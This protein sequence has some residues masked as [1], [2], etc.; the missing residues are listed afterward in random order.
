[1]NFQ[2]TN[3]S[4]EELKGLSIRAFNRAMGFLSAVE[5]IYNDREDQKEAM[6]LQAKRQREYA[7]TCNSY[8]IPYYDC[9]FLAQ[10]LEHEITRIQKTQEEN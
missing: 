3:L 10:E 1:M 8:D 7:K 5:Q 4:E 2:E 9:M 6:Q